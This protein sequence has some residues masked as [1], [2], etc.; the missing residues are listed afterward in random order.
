M[1]NTNLVLNQQFLATLLTQ[2]LTA[3]SLGNKY[4]LMQYIEVI[5]KIVQEER[6]CIIQRVME[7]GYAPIMLMIL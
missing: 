6:G 7:V 3:A 1:L 5:G 2:T 4:V